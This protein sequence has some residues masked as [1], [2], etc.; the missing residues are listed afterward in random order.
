MNYERSSKKVAL[1]SG[2]GKVTGEK[3]GE[4]RFRR[5]SDRNSH[6][7]GLTVIKGQPYD[8]E[9]RKRKIQGRFN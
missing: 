5:M 1:E 3:Q 8:K 9:N 4:E 7:K 6:K 2:R